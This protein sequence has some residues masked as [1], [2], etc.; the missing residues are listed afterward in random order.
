M[1]FVITKPCIGVKDTACIVVC[2]VDCIHP[3]PAEPAFA[4]AEMLHIDPNACTDCSMCAGECPV[5]AIFQ[6]C[7]V[8]TEWSEFVERNASF[9]VK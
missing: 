6:D 2:P 8:P 9:Y 4:P 1:A 5:Q 3:A 7:D